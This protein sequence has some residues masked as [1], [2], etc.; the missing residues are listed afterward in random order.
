MTT[1]NLLSSPNSVSADV[2]LWTW[3]PN[4]GA[5]SL[6][7]EIA[8]L[9]IGT[10]YVFTPPAGA[11]INL[12]PADATAILAGSGG[13]QVEP[14]VNAPGTAGK[15]YDPRFPDSP[16]YTQPPRGAGPA[17]PTPLSVFVVLL[18]PRSGVY[19]WSVS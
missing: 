1:L 7:A 16:I 8:A 3:D 6:L 2:R 13:S 14:G 19:T 5:W 17:A 4:V 10:G 18:N 15:N 11:V 12:P 9:T